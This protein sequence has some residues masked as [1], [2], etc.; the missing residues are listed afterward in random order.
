[1]LD[2]HERQPG[3]E[4]PIGLNS[5]RRVQPR[6]GGVAANAQR[7]HHRCRILDRAAAQG[8]LGAKAACRV[9]G[10]ARTAGAARSVV[11]GLG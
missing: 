10:G 9:A 3:D 1:M 2:K 5:V 8:R 6:T 7:R 11:G 4:S